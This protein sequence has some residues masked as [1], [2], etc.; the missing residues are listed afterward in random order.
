MSPVWSVP[1]MSFASSASFWYFPS[2]PFMSAV[3]MIACAVINLSNNFFDH[4]RLP[5]IEN[6]KKQSPAKTSSRKAEQHCIF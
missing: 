1:R 2:I 5:S 6:I 4:A 3:G